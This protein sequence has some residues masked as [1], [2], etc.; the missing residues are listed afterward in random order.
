MTENHL[1]NGLLRVKPCKP[2]DMEMLIALA[3]ADGHAVIAPT[4]LLFKGEQVV[5][6]LGT[7][8]SILVWLD[9]QRVGV[10]DSI[11]AMNFFENQMAANGAQIIGVPCVANSPLRPFLPKAG[12]SDTGATLFL[13]NLNY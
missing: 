10:R 11:M 6:Y 4:W 8:P 7:V 1:T 3:K 13:K 12:Y 5:G 2:E 9:T